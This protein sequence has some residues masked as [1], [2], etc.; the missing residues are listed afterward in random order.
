MSL[1]EMRRAAF[2]RER[3]Q[4]CTCLPDVEVRL[5]AP[6]TYG[7]KIYHDEDCGLYQLFF[8]RRRRLTRLSCDW[9]SEV[10]SSDLDLPSSRGLVHVDAV[11][12]AG[13][14]PLAEVP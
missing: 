10:C 12:A 3:A 4:G 14:L 13:K 6:N 9:S 1:T 5:V 2:D 11:Q 8:S 7:N